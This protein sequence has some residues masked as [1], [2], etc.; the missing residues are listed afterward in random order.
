LLK[1]VS[2]IAN[3]QATRNRITHGLLDWEYAT[4]DRVRASTFKPSFEFAEH[5]DFRKLLKLSDTIGEINFELTYP[6]GKTQ[7]WKAVG[8][9]MQAQGF[10]MSRDFA[11][12]I[13]G[14]NKSE[15]MPPHR[16]GE[17]VPLTVDD[18]EKIRG[19]LARRSRSRKRK[20]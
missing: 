17:A 8:E 6:K 18:H 7:A 2:R 16:I 12:M 19:I 10:S 20:K 11:L 3:V 13:T 14:K 5:F 4:P 1:L 9:E 15:R